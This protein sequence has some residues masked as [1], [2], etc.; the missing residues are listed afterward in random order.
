[1]NV[2]AELCA[3]YLAMRFKDQKVIIAGGTS[4]IG[5]ATARHFLQQGAIVTITGRKPELLKAAEKEGL[6]AV[7]LDSVDREA[8]N[9]FFSGY[10]PVDHL[11]IAL[12]GAKGVG[13][14]AGLSLAVLREGFAEKFWPQLETLQA[15]L[16]FLKPGGSVTLI[17]AISSIGKMPG[18]S[19]LGAMNGALEVMIPILSRELTTI[20]INAVSPGVVDTPWWDFIPAEARQEALAQYTAGIQAKR[21]AQP[22]EIADAVVFLAGNAYMT[23][24]V[25]WCDGGIA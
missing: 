20:R 2:L 18:T 19:G 12:G 14:F 23:G 13:E 17:T 7:S 22:A 1:V 4:G 10:G 24:K 25:V 6:N 9:S 11:V 5:L 8:L 3:K 16:P 15:S 21:A